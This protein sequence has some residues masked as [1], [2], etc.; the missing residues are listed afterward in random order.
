M[1]PR[2]PDRVVLTVEP[3]PKMLEPDSPS[4]IDPL[5]G[6]QSPDIE[7]TSNRR[8]SH[9]ADNVQL[10]DK[11]LRV[12]EEVGSGAILR[13]D[14]R[15][16]YK[17]VFDYDSSDFNTPEAECVVQESS[18]AQVHQPQEISGGDSKPP[19]KLKEDVVRNG[20]T[21]QPGVASGDSG[22]SS[23]ENMSSSQSDDVSRSSTVPSC[24]GGSPMGNQ[25]T[26]SIARTRPSPRNPVTQ[27]SS[28][29]LL[30]EAGRTIPSVGGSA[31]RSVA[32]PQIN[33]DLRSN[34]SATASSIPR[35]AGATVPH[36]AGTNN[37][38]NQSEKQEAFN[39]W[40]HRVETSGP[41]YE[42]VS[43]A[44][45]STKGPSSCSDKPQVVAAS[46]NNGSMYDSAER[47]GEQ[48]G[49]GDSGVVVDLQGN[50]S[51]RKGRSK[52]SNAVLL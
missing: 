46:G 49:A 18:K 51:L 23:M 20:V 45:K 19:V 34:P 36:G 48:A 32:Q 38:N 6:P 50:T 2:D 28:P 47:L 44:E 11:L 13:T 14:P 43:L 4:S 37:S 27:T 5:I 9:K 42:N 41:S 35:N 52:N 30:N 21:E 33:E 24:H 25:T 39:P 7:L 22:Q 15:G 40:E 16:H 1:R 31:Q 8:C 29:L 10:L 26:N 12:E 3:P 17:R